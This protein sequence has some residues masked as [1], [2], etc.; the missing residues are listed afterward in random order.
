MQASILIDKSM[1]IKKKKK[2]RKKREKGKNKIIRKVL[3]VMNL[4][5]HVKHLFTQWNFELY[6]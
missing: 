6:L 5:Q 4:L 1:Y 2:K 3:C